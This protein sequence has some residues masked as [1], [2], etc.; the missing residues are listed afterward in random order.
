MQRDYAQTLTPK[1]I[2]APV[3]ADNEAPKQIREFKIRAY[4]DSDYQRQSLNWSEGIEAQIARANRV[5]ETQFGVRLVLKEVKPWSRSGQANSIDGALAQ[6]VAL[7]PADDVDWVVGFVSS[8]EVFAATQEQLGRAEIPGHHLVLRGMFSLAEVEALNATLDRLSRQERDNVNRERRLHK[9]T[10]VLLHEW[11]HTL[12]AFHERSSQWIMSPAYDAHQISFSQESA[13][14]L[15]ASLSGWNATDAAGRQSWAKT[16]RE[17][18]THFPPGV[19]DEASL[20]EALS[21]SEALLAHLNTASPAATT[22]GPSKTASVKPLRP[23]AL[24]ERCYLMQSRSPRASETLAACRQATA[25]PGAPLEGRLL[26][27]RVLIARKEISEA[28]ALLERAEMQLS[29]AGVTDTDTWVYLAQLFDRADTCTG[30][31]RVAK[32]VPLDPGAVQVMK[33]CAHQRRSVALPANTKGVPLE[34]EHAYVEAVQRAQRDVDAGRVQRA[35]VQAQELERI[36]PGS[37]GAAL[38][39]CLSDGRENSSVRVK[40]SC[41]GANAAA[42]EAFAPWLLLGIVAGTE[43]RWDDA[44]NLLQRA[45]ELDDGVVEAWRRL[46]VVYNHLGDATSLAELKSRYHARFGGVLPA[47]P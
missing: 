23:D 38:I 29:T 39:N 31:E 13:H 43:K 15:L 6:L 44:R 32:R 47:T 33:D 8:L 45:I 18:V 19:A 11:A 36:F 40:V 7:D 25:D 5:L 30:A 4:A 14:L 46:A 22:M 34:R 3:V 10:V 35:R 27:G 17:E 28:V 1:R 26:L 12:G 9:Q 2:D 42:P 41:A 37:P 16:Y 21:Y 24:L 20:S